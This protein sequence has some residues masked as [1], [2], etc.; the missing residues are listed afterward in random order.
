MGLTEKQSL[1]KDELEEKVYEPTNDMVSECERELPE[2]TKERAARGFSELM[3]SMFMMQ[4]ICPIP[5]RINDLC[6]HGSQHH[7]MEQQ[8]LALLPN[9]MELSFLREGGGS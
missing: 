4:R 2:E 1:E 9:S 6:F 8:S 7:M 5:L 3:Y